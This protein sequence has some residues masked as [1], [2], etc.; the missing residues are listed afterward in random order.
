M[1]FALLLEHENI[2]EDFENDLSTRQAFTA[3]VIAGIEEH[4]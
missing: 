1:D 2:K 4:A 3:V